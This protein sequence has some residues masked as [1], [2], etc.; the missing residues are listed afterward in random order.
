MKKDCLHLGKPGHL[1]AASAL[2]TCAHSPLWSLLGAPSEAP[3][4]SGG[5]PAASGSVASSGLK[6]PFRVRMM[7]DLVGERCK[8]HTTH[9]S[10]QVCG[11][12]Q[13]AVPGIGGDMRL[14]VVA[15]IGLLASLQLTHVRRIL[16]ARVVEFTALAEH[17]KVHWQGSCLHVHQLVIGDGGLP[18]SRV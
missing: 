11:C 3:P 13:W 15:H 6:L 9:S 16:L 14:K 18:G 5:L 10:L 12:T 2:C 4:S 8:S 17:L 1:N 7:G